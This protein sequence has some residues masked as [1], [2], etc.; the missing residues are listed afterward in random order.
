[1]ESP[2]QVEQPVTDIRTHLLDDHVELEELFAGLLRAFECNDRE[3]VSALWT[4]F[5]AGLTEHMDLEDAVLIPA[6]YRRDARAAR[7]LWEEHKHL[8]ARLAELGAAVDLHTIRTETATWFIEELRAHARTE[9]RILY[10]W[11]EGNLAE[12]ERESF[13]T[14]VR[15]AARRLA[16]PETTEQAS[17]RWQL[18][19][20]KRA[21]S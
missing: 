10:S 15:E 8:R 3:Q 2:K 20:A 1:M 17:S 12:D 14:R 13:W 21:T 16:R 9:D 11:A 7:V 4:A 5:D 18:R 19:S 6:L